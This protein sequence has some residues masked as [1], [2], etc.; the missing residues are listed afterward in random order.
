L[1]KEFRALIKLE[2]HETAY[3][4]FMNDFLLLGL[5]KIFW[6]DYFLLPYMNGLKCYKVKSNQST[7]VHLITYWL[8][9]L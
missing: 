2:L 9:M 8:W 3:W 7:N 6:D 4:K 5:I 1:Q